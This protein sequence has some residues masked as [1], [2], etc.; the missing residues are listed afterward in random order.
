MNTAL[1]AAIAE[2]DAIRLAALE[3][4]SRDRDHEIYAARR[5]VWKLESRLAA[6]RRRVRPARAEQVSKLYAYCLS[7]RPHLLASA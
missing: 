3:D 7:R 4:E 6:R 1:L 5:R 2:L